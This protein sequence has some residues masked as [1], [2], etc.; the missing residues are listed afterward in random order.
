MLQTTKFPTRVL[1][2]TNFLSTFDEIDKMMHDVFSNKQ[3]FQNYPPTDVYQKDGKFYMDIIVAGFNKED[4]KIELEDNTIIV[5]AS[6][7]TEE[8]SNGEFK[9]YHKSISYKDIKRS[10][11]F[12]EPIKDVIPNLTNGMLHLE[13]ILET[14]E[15]K[16]RL[17]SFEE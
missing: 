13:I 3:V 16:K 2:P 1:F 7:N 14:P 9:Y 15:S 8:N 12:V 10:I 6:K 17:I 11:S 4:I 5:T